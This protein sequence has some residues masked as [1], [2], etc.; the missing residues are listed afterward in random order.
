MLQF[1]LSKPDRVV[2]HQRIAS[3]LITSKEISLMSSTDLANEETKQSIKIA[4]KEALEHSILTPTAVPR[5]KITHKGLEDIEDI[6]GQRV[7]NTEDDERSRREEEGRRERERM[8]RLRAQTR[9]RAT[10]T[11]VPPESPVT[12]HQAS[13]WGEPPPVPLHAI[14]NQEPVIPS[15]SISTFTSTA[16]PPDRSPQ[17]PE[18]NLSEFINIDDDAP[19]V[20]ENPST[21]HSPPAALDTTTSLPIDHRE[22]SQIPTTGTSPVEAT[23]EAPKPSFDLEALWNKPKVEDPTPTVPMPPPQPLAPSPIAKKPH[24][25]TDVIMESS[26]VVADDNDFDMFLEEKLDLTASSA[27][28]QQAALN[29]LPHVWTGKV[30][31][32]ISESCG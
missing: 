8:A 6:H 25:D 21:S 28:A 32:N 22:G 18:L 29:A 14:L 13:S 4:E 20:I 23:E 19:P 2:L 15:M 17:E 9:Q 5:A 10:S 11:S 30:G 26:S 12:P 16:T 24:H 7:T 27:Q 3:A 31:L 1:N